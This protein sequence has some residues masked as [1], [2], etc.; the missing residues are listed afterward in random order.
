MWVLILSI[1]FHCPTQR[2]DVTPLVLRVEV[3]SGH[4]QSLEFYKVPRSMESQNTTLVTEQS[5][6][7]RSMR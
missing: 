2:L 1:E 7:F 4:N 5:F 3:I 6:T